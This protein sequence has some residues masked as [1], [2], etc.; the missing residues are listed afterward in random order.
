[1]NPPLNNPV[2]MFNLHSL[3]KKPAGKA[4]KKVKAEAY[5]TYAKV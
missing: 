5:W 1:M 4:Q 3:F 2:K